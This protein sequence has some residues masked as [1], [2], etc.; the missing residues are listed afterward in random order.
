MGHEGIV[1]LFLSYKADALLKDADDNTAVH[2][3]IQQGHQN[4]VKILIEKYPELSTLLES[5]EDGIT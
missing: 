1:K 5:S 3:A 4:V 2:K